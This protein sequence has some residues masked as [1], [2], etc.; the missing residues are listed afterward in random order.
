MTNSFVNPLKLDIN[1]FDQGIGMKKSLFGLI[2]FALASPLFADQ[3]LYTAQ[4]LG[5]G[6]VTV[7]RNQNPVVSIAPRI[8]LEGYENVHIDSW[9]KDPVYNGMATLPTGEQVGLV[10]SVT[11]S[12]GEIHAHYRFTPLKDVKVFRVQGLVYWP[13]PDWVG[14]PYQ[15]GES[16]GVVPSQKKKNF[17]LARSKADSFSLGP[18]AS[19]ELT[20]QVKGEGLNWGLVDPGA[21]YP[22]LGLVLDHHEPEDKTWVWKAGE[23]KDF[24]YTVTLN[25]DITTADSL[26]RTNQEGFE[27]TWYGMAQAKERRLRTA[28][29]ITRGT[30]GKWTVYYDDL[31]GGRYHQVNKNVTVKGNKLHWGIGPDVTDMRLDPKTDTIQGEGSYKGFTYT[32]DLKRG[33]NYTLPRVDVDGQAVTDYSYQVPQTLDDGWAVGDLKDSPLNP[34]IV[35]KGIQEILN[36]KYLN[37]QGLVVVQKGK[38]LVDEYFEGFGPGDMHQLQSVSK[39]VFSI[40]F[41]IAQDQGLMNLEDKLYDYYPDYRNKPNWT[42][43]KGRIKLKHLL[44][45]SSGYDCDDWMAPADKCLKEMLKSPDWISLILSEP[46]AHEPGTHFAYSSSSMEPLGEILKNKSGL[47]V[48]DFA[49]KYLNDPLGIPYFHWSEGPH[50]VVGI[51]GGDKLRP[52]DMAKLGQ[53]YL[54]NGRWKDKQIVSKR[55][56]EDSTQPQVPN[57]KEGHR[58][59]EYGYLWWMEQMPC[60]GKMVRVFYA[61]G[62]GGQFIFVVPELELVCAMTA[63]DYQYDQATYPG[64][65]FF[66][67]YILGAF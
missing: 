4:V 27:G 5:N 18:T 64:H 46:M 12:G 28:L 29:L 9:V 61:A 35:E 13:Y 37:Q 58:Y 32:L 15:M 10:S 67:T 43:Q 62:K 19:E 14:A 22:F 66:E 59:F 38:L 50:E 36:Q 21:A 41:G 3:D 49:Q 2:L 24:D 53:L 52:R 56:V 40:L 7:Y 31:E 51:S 65:D 55:W 44:S 63:G 34:K 26:S 16:K 6:V 60:Q 30:D 20:F 33:L 23:T 25:H 45:M 17:I 42:D 11:V 1:T 54:Q 8:Y 47:S 39:S 48:S 57:P